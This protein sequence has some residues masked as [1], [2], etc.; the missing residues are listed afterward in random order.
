MTV[1]EL[2][3]DELIDCDVSVIEFDVLRNDAVI[4]DANDTKL[5]VIDAE[6]FVRPCAAPAT[7]AENVDVKPTLKEPPGPPSVAVNGFNT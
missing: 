5:A 2:A 7:D 4:D 6:R 3:I 1:D